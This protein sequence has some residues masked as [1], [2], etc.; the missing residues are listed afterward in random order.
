T[1]TTT[2]TTPRPTTTARATTTALPCPWLGECTPD[3]V[4]G[5]WGETPAVFSTITLTRAS[6]SSSTF[7]FSFLLNPKDA[8]KGAAKVWHA[9]E[10]L[11]CVN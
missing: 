6:C 4:R 1:T 3:D 8:A 7:R 11:D 10:A 2:T 9:A 5:N